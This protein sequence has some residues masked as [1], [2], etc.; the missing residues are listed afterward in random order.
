M[1]A[2]PLAGPVRA[3]TFDLDFTLWDLSGVL[4]HAEQVCQGFIEQRY[5][6]VAKRYDIEG[7][8]F[9][10]PIWPHSTRA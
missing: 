9:C 4:R 2:R 3:V 10:V 6:A 8:R 7:L 5:P 1:T